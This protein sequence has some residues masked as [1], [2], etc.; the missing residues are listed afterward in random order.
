[1]LLQR[2]GIIILLFALI[3]SILYFGSN[4]NTNQKGPDESENVRQTNNIPLFRTD[5]TNPILPD[6]IYPTIENAGSTEVPEFELPIHSNLV[7]SNNLPGSNRKVS[8]I[9]EDNPEFFNNQDPIFKVGDHA[10]VNYHDLHPSTMKSKTV[11]DFIRTNRYFKQVLN[12]NEYPAS[13][14]LLNQDG[15]NRFGFEL[16]L[17]IK[18]V[19]VKDFSPTSTQWIAGEAAGITVS[20]IS[21][22]F[23]LETGFTYSRLEFDDEI[24]IRYYS[25]QF[26]GSVI[27]F[28]N[29]EVI[30]YVDEQ[31]DTITEN[32]YHPELVD[33]YDST[34]Q[35]TEKPDR[36]KLSRIEIP[37]IVG[38]RIKESGRY[39]M[40]VKTGLELSV[41]SSMKMSGGQ[42]IDG[43]TRIVAIDS[44]LPDKYSVKWK[45]HLSL[46]V[47]L[48][49][50]EKLSL[51]GEPT[52]LWY[53]EP[54]RNVG[55]GEMIKPFEVGV[56]VGIRWAF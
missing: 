19:F 29:Y 16:G 31:G 25:Y 49:I 7:P 14:T 45:Y 37:L 48:R 54:M 24:D 10:A 2:A 41:I 40:D 13:N 18:P 39:F 3:S 30:E 12:Q 1:K 32:R 34:F 55:S 53:L 4:F 47:G 11:N 21:S 5:S 44:Q 9:P 20:M 26:L 8:G 35:E 17:F 27:S 43:D 33:L 38:Y 50:G 22:R 46:G 56:K 28:E 52:M 36:I 23:L 51:Y 15:K 6:E 42:T